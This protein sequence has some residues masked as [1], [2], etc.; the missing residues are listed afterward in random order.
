MKNLSLSFYFLYTLLLF[1]LNISVISSQSTNDQEHYLSMNFSQLTDTTLKYYVASF[2]KMG[3]L[4]S[5]SVYSPKQR[6]LL[7]S[8]SYYCET[9]SSVHTGIDNINISFFAN[10]GIEEF[11]SQNRKISYDDNNQSIKVDGLSII[12]TQQIPKSQID[13]IRFCRVGC[14][15]LM[16]DLPQ[17]AINDIFEPD[18]CISKQKNWIGKESCN[19]CFKAFVSDFWTFIYLQ[20][21]TAGNKYEVTWIIKG[22]KYYGR[23]IDKLPDN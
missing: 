5:F 20:G 19:S 2:T 11:K 12:G 4:K 1:F 16:I 14:R 8:K 15:R 7:E 10:I 17:V 6:K 21:G 13:G 9:T 3:T 22:D 18:L 23:I